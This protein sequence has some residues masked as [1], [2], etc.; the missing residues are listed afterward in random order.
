MLIICNTDD[1]KY[2]ASY[3]LYWIRCAEHN[4]VG[5]QG[6]VGVTMDI[7]KRLV[8]HNRALSSEKYKKLQGYSEDFIENFSKG[9]LIA[10][11]IDCGSIQSI[12]NKE[13]LLRPHANIGWNV[14]KGGKTPSQ[15]KHQS[16]GDRRFAMLN[17]FITKLQSSGVFIDKNFMTDDGVKLLKMHEPSIPMSSKCRLELKDTSIGFV[18]GNFYYYDVDYTKTKTFEHDGVTWT[19]ADACKHNKVSLNTACKRYMVYGKSIQESV[20][21]VSFIPKCYEIVYLD[22]VPCKYSSKLSKHSKEDLV[23]IYEFYKQE[24]SGFKDYCKSFGI[25]DSNMLRYFKRYGLTT[26]VDRRTKD[27]RSD[28]D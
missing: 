10:S 6:Y 9:D 17:R 3:Y 27:F 26:S 13:K 15:I 8:S 22:G 11:I 16:S 18:L 4:D 1:I 20:G 7:K 2:E 12:L 23:K 19:F 24:K 25:E 28:S 14:S 5:S 21:F